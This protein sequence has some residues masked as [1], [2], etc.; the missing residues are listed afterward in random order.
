MNKKYSK[1]YLSFSPILILDIFKNILFKKK[2]NIKRFY[3]IYLITNNEDNNLSNKL[4]KVTDSM[5]VSY[6][7]V[8]LAYRFKRLKIH[9]SERS[10]YSLPFSENLDLNLRYLIS[11]I[12]LIIWRYN[13]LDNNI[14]IYLNRLED[15]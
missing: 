2:F 4:K 1:I 12:D 3:G 13:I 14:V 5:Y 15:N 8:Q 10:Y 11:I 9:K 7:I 6:Y